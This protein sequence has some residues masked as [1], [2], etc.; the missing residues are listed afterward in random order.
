VI[1][2]HTITTDDGV[3]RYANIPALCVANEC[4]ANNT[5]LGFIDIVL[6]ASYARAGAF[7][8]GCSVGWTIRADF[9]DADDA[10]L[11][12]F[13]LNNSVSSGPLFG[14]WEDAGGIARIRFTGLTRNGSVGS[15]DNLMVETVVG[16]PLHGRLEIDIKPGTYPNPIN[17]FIPGV[18]P[19]AILGSETFDVADVDVTTL[20]FGPDGAAPAHAVGGHLEDVNDD[21]LMDLLSHYQTEETGIASGDTEACVTGETLDG[22]PFEGCDDINTEPPCGNGY[23]AALVV[24]PLLWIGGRRRRTRA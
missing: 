23:A 13:N 11:G 8:S 18:I 16:P 22:A 17:P 21:S 12:S 19:V 3:F 9:F 7:V 15:L 10:L 4:I 2:G 1:D 24:P 14:G 6:G 20:A 5:D